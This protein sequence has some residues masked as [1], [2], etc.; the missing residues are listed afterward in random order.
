[1]WGKGR[2]AD[3]PSELQQ[4]AA[5]A[6]ALILAMPE[7][8]RAAVLAA[9]ERMARAGADLRRLP[10]AVVEVLGKMIFRFILELHLPAVRKPT[11][12]QLVRQVLAGAPVLLG[13]HKEAIEG[14]LV[15][16]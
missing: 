4:R 5:E 16:G 15:G 8:D 6:E 1:M 12:E 2:A 9:V 11:A 7:A 13:A 10:D 3:R 14:A